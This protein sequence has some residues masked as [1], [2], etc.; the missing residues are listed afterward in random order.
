MAPCPRF[1][2]AVWSALLF[3]LLV[4]L[5]GRG[6]A[7]NEPPPADATP[8][9]V[10]I[11]PTEARRGEMIEIKGVTGT[12]PI[13]ILLDGRRAG[14]VDPAANGRF[15]Y[16]IPGCEGA[17]AQ[18]SCT[19]S[20]QQCA[21]E[22]DTT[23]EACQNCRFPVDLGSHRLTVRSEGLP[24]LTTDLK[25]L[26]DS[27]GAPEI[28]AIYPTTSYPNYDGEDRANPRYVLTIQGK[29]F[30]A[31]GCDNELYLG[32]RQF[33]NI[34]WSGEA[35][36]QGLTS[37]IQG[38][39]ISSRA[40]EFKNLTRD[41][42]DLPSLSIGVAGVRSEP[43]DVALSQ[44]EKGFPLRV[45]SA[46]VGGLLALTLL[47]GLGLRRRKIAGRQ[48]NIFSA[49]VLDPET[50]TY[51]LSRFQFY[52]W[53]GI[54]IF[55]YV[56]LAT[57]R[58]LVQGKLEFIDVPEGLPGIVFISAATSF[59]AQWTQNSKG[60]KG[61]GDVQPSW[62]DFISSGGV[63]A[64][65]RFQFF[66]WTLLGAGAFVMLILLREPGTITDLPKVPQ[67]FLN[68]MGISSAGYLGGKL[69]RKP[70]PIIDEIVAKMGSLVLS[71]RGRGLSKDAS[72]L[73]EDVELNSDMI[74]AKEWTRDD[75]SSEPGMNKGLDIRIKTLTEEWKTAAQPL[76]FTVVNPDGQKAVWPFVIKPVIASSELPAVSAQKMNKEVEVLGQGFKKDAQASVTVPSGIAAPKATLRFVSDTRVLVD[77]DATETRL[78]GQEPAAATLVITNPDGGSVS[79]PLKITAAATNPAT[80]TVPTG[81][82]TIGGATPAPITTTGGTASGGNPAG[83][84]G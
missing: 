74:E 1:R 71:V 69:A 25:I 20:C 61:A 30:S 55:G 11:L 50:D 21:V 23:S 59:L 57:S 26:K 10:T 28:T 70:G 62:A 4:P 6:F 42:E 44:V 8:P 14:T 51:S 67:G 22:K 37:F 16:T 12:Q 29:G 33:D 48:H 76:H 35:W 66:V 73:I 18:G 43:K 56:Y 65:E 79:V 60:P 53:T 36:C 5:P 75:L 3:A 83:A 58:S 34:C 19:K 40:L 9:P 17:C 63:V 77:I 52:L 54:A 45:A 7:E 80:P 72:F 47:I 15:F 38:R 68:I 32:K 46:V 27:E 31:N 84:A 2:P 82:T 64:P 39:A 13:E 24:L 49:L 78:A 41:P 81:G